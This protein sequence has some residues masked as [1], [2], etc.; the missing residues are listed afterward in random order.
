MIHLFI[1][2]LAASA[3]GGLTYIRN[4]VPHIAGR[5]GV[6]ATVLLGARLGRELQASSNLTFVE[7][8][9]CSNVALRFFEEQRIVRD[10]VRQCAAD[11]LLSAGN[12][13]LLNSPVPQILLSRNSLYTSRD[14]YL[15]LRSRGDYRL[16]L[17]TQLKSELARLSIQAADT[18][19]A[20]SEAFAEELRRWTGNSVAAIHHGFDRDAFVSDQSPL[21]RDTQ[22]KLDS[23]REG[24]R[25]LFV[26]HY[27]YYRNFETLI[28]ALALIKRALA[29]RE[30]H[31][32][33]T[34]KL[35]AGENPGAYR[36]DFAAALVRELGLSQ[37]VV[38]LG[39][40]PYQRLYQVYQAAHI[41]VTP[42]YAESF[43]HPLVEAMSSGL[44]V[45]ASDLD[46]H[47]EIC[48]SAAVYFSRFSPQELAKRILEVDLSSELVSQLSQAGTKQ[49][50]KFSWKRH[51]DQ[52]LSLAR[53]LAGRAD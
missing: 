43:A 25:L 42:A 12:F 28:R 17:D 41:Y 19:V 3:G 38:E 45:V 52:I 16:W 8:N 4:V 23:G 51:L 49:V 7:R 30:V 24:L 11:V 53:R 21:P 14:F 1:N 29:P 13:A 36:T 35:A 18:V 37:E 34:C 20:P 27:N 5:E 22:D 48:G 32:F 39:T 47:R 2:A 44:P 31:L 9:G 33:L 46:V 50:A 15:D 6:K 40:V 26:S 10:L